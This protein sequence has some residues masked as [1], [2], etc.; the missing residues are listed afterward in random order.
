VGTY[1]KIIFYVA[2]FLKQKAERR[3]LQALAGVPTFGKSQIAAE[4]GT[5]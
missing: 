1:E 2:F 5:G 3:S 4:E